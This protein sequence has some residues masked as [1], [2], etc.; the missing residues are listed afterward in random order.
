VCDG[1][2]ALEVGVEGRDE[3]AVGVGGEVEGAGAD[4]GVLEG[5]D[6]V[7]DDGV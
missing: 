2:G 3:A 6:G 5:F 4:V 1:V 7:V